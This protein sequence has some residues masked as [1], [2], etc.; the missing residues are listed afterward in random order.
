MTPGRARGSCSTSRCRDATVPDYR[1]RITFPGD[2]VV[3]I[4]DPYRYGQRA[5][6]FRSAPVRRRHASSR[7]RQARRA[8]HRR[9]ASTTG[10]H[11]AVWAPNAAARQR[12][13]RLQRLGRPRRIRCGCSSPSGVWEIFVPDLQDGEKYKFEIRTAGGRAAEEDRSRTGSPSRCRRRPLRSCATS[14]ATSGRTP[15]GW[16]TRRGARRLA[17][18]A[19]VDLRGASRLVGACAGGRRPLSDLP[20]AGRSGW[21]PT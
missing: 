12:R 6:R 2:H 4:D 20:R 18:P 15:S 5:D 3:E 9:S 17:A 19:D 8:P 1:L 13:R 10:V 16:R 21:C 7:V 11:F 14:P